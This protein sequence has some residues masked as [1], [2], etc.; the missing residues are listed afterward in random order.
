MTTKA[1]SL[2]SYC[3]TDVVQVRVDDEGGFRDRISRSKEVR[4]NRDLIFQKNG[5]PED[6]EFV[7]RERGFSLGF[8][9]IRGLGLRIESWPFLSPNQANPRCLFCHAHLEEAPESEQLGRFDRPN[10]E[11]FTGFL[12]Q[13]MLTCSVCGWW[14]LVQQDFQHAN[15]CS[16]SLERTYE[17]R[18]CSSGKAKVYSV[19]DADVP[20]DELRRWLSKHPDHVAHTDAFHFERLMASCFRDSFP[21]AEVIHLGGRRDHGIDLKLI[22]TEMGTVLV[23]VKRRA[24][25]E[26]NE[27]VQ[28]VRELNGVML[29]EGVPRGIVVT[30]A[31]GYT[32][33]AKEEAAHVQRAYHDS[34]RF[35][36]Y[37]VDLL[38]FDDV[39]KLLELPTSTP[40]PWQQTFQEALEAKRRLQAER[41]AKW[42]EEDWW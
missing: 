21:N 13:V 7:Q 18:A 34:D 33:D 39:V 32:K 14:V 27:S 35:S 41:N 1:P 2:V 40:R 17:L 3:E 5:R 10:D 6:F 4:L 42:R 9:E 16:N 37:R 29:R 12:F 24:N 38:A 30:T 25:L 11:Y 15:A 26:R 36:R 31:K 20:L 23:Q 28:V 22:Q 19:S 8:D